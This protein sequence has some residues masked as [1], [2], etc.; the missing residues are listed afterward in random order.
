MNQNI[1]LMA[2]LFIKMM[3]Y[4]Q[5]MMKVKYFKVIFNKDIMIVIHLKYLTK[6]KTEKLYFY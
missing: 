5:L 1:H 3:N 6:L 2:H 4:G